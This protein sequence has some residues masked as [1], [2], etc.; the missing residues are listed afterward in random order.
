MQR[1]KQWVK[2]KNP[3]SVDSI[4]V[5]VDGCNAHSDLSKTPTDEV[6]NANQQKTLCTLYR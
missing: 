4:G 6:E 3:Y 1:L 5:V 2:M